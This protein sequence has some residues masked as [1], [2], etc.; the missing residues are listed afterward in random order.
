MSIKEKLGFSKSSYTFFASESAETKATIS[1]S[2]LAWA[3]IFVSFGITAR[4]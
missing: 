1:S 2:A 3:N 4:G